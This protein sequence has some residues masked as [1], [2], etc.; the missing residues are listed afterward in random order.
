MEPIAR[1]DLLELVGQIDD[2]HGRA[3]TRMSLLKNTFTIHFWN[4][5][6]NGSTHLAALLLLLATSHQALMLTCDLLKGVL[7]RAATGIVSNG[8]MIVTI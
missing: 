7:K 2:D 3:L 4:L 5:I 6:F 1:Q 8:T